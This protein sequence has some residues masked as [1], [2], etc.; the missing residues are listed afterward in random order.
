M[1]IT[2]SSEEDPERERALLQDFTQRRVDGLLVVPAGPDH[3]FL[4]R[5][6]E[7]GMPVVFLD[8]PPQGLL[9][10]AVLLDNQGG[11]R[12]GVSALLDQGHRRVGVLLGAPSV[13]TIRERLVGARAALAAA[14]STPTSRWSPTA[15]PRRRRPGRRFPRC[16]TYRPRRPPSS[17]PTTGS[18]SVRSRNCTGGA[19]MPR[20]SAS[21]TSSS[22]T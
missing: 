18:P 15:S 20:W 7:L 22:P 10:D 8:R 11:S 17:A 13:P 5:E 12:A 19:A 1:L 3:S 16:S 6:V 2:A 21:T 4:R 9:V 14:G